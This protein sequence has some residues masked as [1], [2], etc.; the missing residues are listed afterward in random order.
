[1]HVARLFDEVEE[2]VDELIVKKLC[3][4]SSAARLQ[5]HRQDIPKS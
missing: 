2:V 5:L 1:M 4:I 3:N